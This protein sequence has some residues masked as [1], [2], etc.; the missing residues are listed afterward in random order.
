MTHRALTVS[1]DSG[2]VKSRTPVIG[3]RTAESSSQGRALPSFVLVRSMTWPMMM[4]V[5]ASMI[6][7]TIGKTV[8]KAPPHSVVSFRTSV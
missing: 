5:I 1:L 6:F 7:D 8:R 3:T 4:F 2:T